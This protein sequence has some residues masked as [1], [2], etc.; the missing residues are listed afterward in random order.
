MYDMYI[1]D[2]GQRKDIHAS[3][4]RGS[5]EEL[6]GLPP[7]LIQVAANDIL[8]DEGEAYGRK[9]DEAGVDVTTIRYDGMIHDFGLLNGLANEPGTR[10]LSR[11]AAAELKERLE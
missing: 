1:A 7:A 9:L 8:R 4:L 11:H 2:P 3:P 5:I 6:K 10:S